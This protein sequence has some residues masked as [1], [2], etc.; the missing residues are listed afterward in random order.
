MFAGRCGTLRARPSSACGQHSY[1][2]RSLDEP[3]LQLIDLE[4]IVPD[5]ADWR[6]ERMP[7]LPETAH[8]NRA[9]D[10]IC[11]VLSRSTEAIDRHKKLPLYAKHGVRHVWLVDPIAKALEV[12]ALDDDHRWRDVHIYEGDA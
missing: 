11:E 3:E 6:V 8:L 10:W 4:P 7:T 5:L 9:P 2:R 12:H 1:R